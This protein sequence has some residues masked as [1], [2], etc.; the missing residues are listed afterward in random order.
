MP[1]QLYIVL[2]FGNISYN[3]FRG[4]FYT[5]LYVHLYSHTSHLKSITS[6]FQSLNCVP[7]QRKCI[8]HKNVII[9]VSISKLFQIM[10][11]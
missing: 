2:V 6:A 11:F 9:F 1:Y 3:I 10:K 4:F 5:Y 7:F 8:Y